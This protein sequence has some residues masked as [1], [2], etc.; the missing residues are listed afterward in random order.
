MTF[1]FPHLAHK[2]FMIE[3]ILST[4]ALLIGADNYELSTFFKARPVL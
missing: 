3:N 1:C 2:F 4:D